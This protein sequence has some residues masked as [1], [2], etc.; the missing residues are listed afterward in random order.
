VGAENKPGGLHRYVEGGQISG[1]LEKGME[2]CG[3][4]KC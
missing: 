2:I 3:S 4:R 1:S